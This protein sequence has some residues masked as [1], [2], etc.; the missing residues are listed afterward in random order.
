MAGD[1]AGVG[2]DGCTVDHS[3]SAPCFIRHLAEKAGVDVTVCEFCGGKLNAANP[4]RR[5]TDGAAAHERC[6]QGEDGTIF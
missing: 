1:L 4:W 5:G 6:L 2:A 3:L